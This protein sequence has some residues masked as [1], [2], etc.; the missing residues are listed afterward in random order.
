MVRVESSRPSPENQKFNIADFSAG[1]DVLLFNDASQKW[2]LGQVDAWKDP[3]QNADGKLLGSFWTLSRGVKDL[4]LTLP[5]KKLDKIPS[6]ADEFDINGKKYKVDITKT[7]V[8]QDTG[9]V[10][11]TLVS[12]SNSKD[13]LDNINLK[14]IKNLEAIEKFETDIKIKIS[15]FKKEVTKNANSRA[16][17]VL[18]ELAILEGKI[19][20]VGLELG[21]L[22]EWQEIGKSEAEQIGREIK[23]LQEEA[24]AKLAELE[25]KLNGIGKRKNESLSTEAKGLQ[26]RLNDDVEMESKAA[27]KKHETDTKTFEADLAAWKKEKTDYDKA[28]TKK[29]EW[30]KKT[31]PTDTDPGMPT[32]LRPEPVK[33]ELDLNPIKN[34][35]AAK[36]FASLDIPA[37]TGK[38]SEIV[39]KVNDQLDAIAKA[40][41]FTDRKDAGFVKYKDKAVAEIFQ[42]V[43]E[44]E[45]GVVGEEEFDFVAEQKE[46]KEKTTELLTR[47]EKA[48]VV[49][50]I[51]KTAK[52]TTQSWLNDLNVA[53]PA[54]QEKEVLRIWKEMQEGELK[55]YEAEQTKKEVPEKAEKEKDLDIPDA[56]LREL[57]A[58]RTVEVRKAMEAIYT[59]KL[60][61]GE[62][63]TNDEAVL[64]AV[65]DLMSKPPSEAL[66][67]KLRQYGI[68]NW[69][70]FKKVW[71]DKLAKKAVG[72]L[73]QWGRADLDSEVAKQVG[74]WDTFKALKWQIG[75]QLAVTIGCG[76]GGAAAMTAI[77]A[78]G[79][80]AGLG[81]VAAG[82]AGGIGIRNIIRKMFGKSEW[83]ED[84]KK[85]ALEEMFENKRKDIVTSILDKRFGGSGRNMMTGETNVLFSSI[86][87]EAIRT[88]SDEMVK[89]GADAVDGSQ[90]LK[91]DQKRLYINALKNA[92]ESGIEYSTEQKIKFVLALKELKSRGEQATAQ[93]VKDSDL[94]VVK[95]MEFGLGGLSGKWTDSKDFA[96]TGWVATLGIG[97]A[98]AVATSSAEY[99][100]V[101]R[102]VMGGL[103]GGVAGYKI[104]ESFRQ[105]REVKQAEANFNPRLETALQNMDTYLNSPDSFTDVELKAFGDEIKKLNRLF[106]GEAD[107]TEEKKV[108][109]LLQATPNLR[110][111]TENL[112]YQAYRRGLFARINLAEM[113]QHAQ[114]V[115][116]DSGIKLADSTKSWLKKRGWQAGSMAVGAAVGAS[117]SILLGIGARELREYMQPDAID[118]VRKS[119]VL[120]KMATGMAVTAG[121]DNAVHNN[122]LH[123]VGDTQS[124]TP[125]EHAPEIPARP[126]G[127]IEAPNKV[128]GVDDWRHQIMEKMGYKF[129]GGKIDHALRFHPGAKIALMHHDGTPVVD[130]KGHAVEYTFKKGGSTWDAL[131][132]LQNKAKGLIKADDIPT[133][134]I[135]GA[136]TGKVEVLDNYR[137][138]SHKGKELDWS[139]PKMPAEPKVEVPV[140]DVGPNEFKQGYW[141]KQ[142]SVD[143]PNKGGKGSHSL[144]IDNK[145]STYYGRSGKAYEPVYSGPDKWS[146]E[147]FAFKD[148]KGNLFDSKTGEYFA[149]AGSKNAGATREDLDSYVSHYGSKGVEGAA[150]TSWSKGGV[151]ADKGG[152]ESML[153]GTP[154]GGPAAEAVPQSGAKVETVE[155][156]QEPVKTQ[157]PTSENIPDGFKGHDAEYK[158]MQDIKA[159]VVDALRKDQGFVLKDKSGEMNKLLAQVQDSLQKNP[160][161]FKDSVISGALDSSI[162][163]STYE[164]LAILVEQLDGKGIMNISDE[165][166]IMLE[167]KMSDNLERFNQVVNGE[168]YTFT[169]VKGDGGHAMS[170]VDSEGHRLVKTDPKILFTKANVISFLKK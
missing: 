100:S 35:E 11:L 73:D 15:D 118:E 168:N 14:T 155:P 68:K 165:Q 77:F 57:F 86:M 158:V 70:Q 5:P 49:F 133:I 161:L 17:E 87:A 52:E 62:E 51:G 6:S 85:K 26:D 29:S 1:T 95:M 16:K 46:L 159:N 131:D 59:E 112:V 78:S 89:E 43:L 65:K 111:R 61:T 141:E 148:D 45:K 162:A 34:Q 37:T 76:V 103:A 137:V 126:A 19:S 72:V 143:I 135:E 8:I 83:L 164:R 149:T 75:A 97:S 4:E 64:L 55:V 42:A 157:V 69:D 47:A 151:V 152:L 71:N 94:S 30:D 39:K 140:R 36:L 27:K 146:E 114:E 124:S 160:D 154:A 136:D 91:G 98:V 40:R 18:K 38:F 167:L 123:F 80:A 122:D 10:E 50:V 105:K 106:K 127:M 32:A 104:G 44:K 54:D 134:K 90:D 117:A 163:K 169:V 67:Q 113:Q 7:L 13:R 31:N 153:K 9:E 74:A 21:K 170:A 109:A 147:L 129:H 2:E 66:M 23:R 41:G 24:K 116:A 115:S 79:G 93:A 156:V 88:A 144:T 101:A 33:P 132:H 125:I 48:G 120:S 99:S 166:N 145:N 130:A 22:S 110:Q 63:R 3:V 121:V 142:E 82:G 102:G 25:V 53:V 128:T 139:L 60:K 84:R 92:R 108:V 56:L 150:Q 107:T 119:A 58:G 12:V 28:V 138:E 20:D 96:A 81:L